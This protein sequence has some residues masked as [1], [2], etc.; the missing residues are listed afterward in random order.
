MPKK[1]RVGVPTTA[2]G[3]TLVFLKYPGIYPLRR[4]VA[5]TFLT[6]VTSGVQCTVMAL[7]IAIGH[8]ILYR[9]DAVPTFLSCVQLISQ[10]KGNK[11]GAESFREGSTARISGESC[12]LDLDCNGCVRLYC[13][14]YNR[15]HCGV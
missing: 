4:P 12:H 2:I 15:I 8:L 10:E 5:E 14:L 1:K 13:F 6:T 3:Q 9:L 7:C 11:M